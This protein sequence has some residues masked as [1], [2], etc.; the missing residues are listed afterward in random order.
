MNTFEHNLDMLIK[1]VNDESQDFNE[2]TE[3][4]IMEMQLA[5]KKGA[6]WPLSQLHSDFLT[7]LIVNKKR[8]P[9][10]LGA[11]AEGVFDYEIAL[12][13]FPPQR[14]TEQAPV[15]Q[16]NAPPTVEDSSHEDVAMEEGESLL[17]NSSE[18]K[19]ETNINK[20]PWMSDL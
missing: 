20:D 6:T 16:D 19:S 8:I 4:L 3:R 7:I 12:Q 5:F 18:V 17:V 15:F 13:R 9:E 10:H 11:W 2:K 1:L 14:K